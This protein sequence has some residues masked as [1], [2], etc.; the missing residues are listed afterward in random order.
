MI[1]VFS[2]DHR[3]YCF[4]DDRGYVEIC[5]YDRRIL[6]ERCRRNPSEMSNKL[7]PDRISHLDRQGE[8]D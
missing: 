8:D 5:G 4:H 7:G 2:D 6:E 3:F 1:F